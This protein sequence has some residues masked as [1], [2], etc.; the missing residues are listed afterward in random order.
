MT[1]P[2]SSRDLTAVADW[3]E[4]R[5]DDEAAAE[6]TERVAADPQLRADAEFVR[7]VVA[8]RA[9]LPLVEPPDLLRQRLRQQFRR[10]VSEQPSRRTSVLELTA[11]LV[12]DSRRHRLALSTRRLSGAW[13]SRDL[14]HLVWRTGLAE[15]V[16]DVRPD[17][18]GHVRLDGQVLLEHDSIS[19][20]FEAVVTGPGVSVTALDGDTL[21]RF[22]VRAPRGAT[23][24]RVSNGELAIVAELDL[25]GD[26]P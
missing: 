9:D 22:R 18:D 17:G 12:H 1:L 23:S 25:G 26:G 19:S 14:V 7:R 15:L 5:L 8:A 3:V 2:P 16:V 6:M 13:S 20:V 24:L 21:G 11:T 10:W 4:G